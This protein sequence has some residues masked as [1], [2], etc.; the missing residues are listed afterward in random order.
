M[1]KS[2]LPSVSRRSFLHLSAAASAAA[3]FRIVTGPM[4]ARAQ[5]KNISKTACE[6]YFWGKRSLDIIGRRQHS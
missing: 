2:N 5:A 6:E 1:L 4:L 3:T